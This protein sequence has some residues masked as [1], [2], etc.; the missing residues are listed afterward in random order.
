MNLK[1][2]LTST[3]NLLRSIR[4]GEALS[5]QS[6]GGET[7]PGQGSIW[8]RSI[9]LRDVFSRRPQPAQP[10]ADIPADT[11][12]PATAAP[13]AAAPTAAPAAAAQPQGAGASAQAQGPL[14]SR[15][16]S[17]TDLLTRRN[18]KP[19]DCAAESG[20]A[21]KPFWHRQIGF[22]HSGKPYSIGISTT[23]PTL[24]LAV[25]KRS[26]GAVTAARRFP[27]RPE[28]APGEKGF[29]ALLRASLSALGYGAA[30]ADA[31]AVLR[32][33]D[34]DLNVLAVPKL[35]GS[36]LDAA[37]YW[38]LQKEKK[39]AEAE[40]SLDY[41]VLGPTTGSKEPRLDVLTCL[42]RRADAERLRDSFQEAGL[43]LAGVTAI[44]SALLALYRQP[45]AP[46]GYAL[47]AN[48][49]VEPDFSAIGLYTKDRLLFSRFIRSGAGSMAETLMDYFQALAK[50]KPANQGDLELP[51]PGI[52]AEAADAG[53]EPPQ[54]RDADQA[55]ELLRHV[56]LGGPCPD[57]ATP[58]H[59]L[60]PQQMIEAI[61]P[62]IERLARQVER[63]LEYYASS[64]QVRCDALHL[65]G[66]IFASPAIAQALAG[67]LGFPAVVFNPVAILRAD[68]HCASPEDSMALAPALAAALAQPD[69][70]INL[71][72]NYKVRT[73]QDAK[74]AATRSIILGL[75]GVMMLIGAA[76]VVLERGN[77]GKRKELEALKAQTATLG[78]MADENALKLT[79]EQFTQRQEA[80]RLAAGRLLA[81]AAL[82]DISRRAPEN[83][84]ILTLTADYPAPE[85]AKPGAPPLPGQPPA[86]PQAPKPAAG[87]QGSIVI[88]GVVMGERSGF[89]AA[90]SRF[91]IELQASPMFQMPVVNESGL[92]ELGSGG[93]V[94]YF[95]MH[96]GV[97]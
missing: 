43:P 73:A 49:H 80:L 21:A 89:D 4:S 13:A 17:L 78:P 56:L 31:W 3:E 23:G 29:P 87:G 38:T 1:E 11:A 47:A 90:L 51:L 14:W 82:A 26:S 85:A 48:I 59:L 92:K 60:T 69:K 44:P 72:A 96:V 18:A 5:P 75:A 81:P 52:E 50:P 39:F 35:S 7:A 8:T 68:A 46:A 22:G 91:V 65:S 15:R 33:S 62:A 93:Q 63:T 27:M 71:I 54:L 95:V 20:P 94:L 66:E 70:G 83:V 34:L 6:K 37:V 12:T 36:K 9:S 45:G 67:Q 41:L 74:R 86:P 42:A 24:C 64:Q 79:V 88:E 76:G 84:R 32:S 2:R 19:A 25:V 10:A 28:Q 61:S 57:F 77:T 16:I 53:H 55:H 30:N 40:Y 97:R 58:E